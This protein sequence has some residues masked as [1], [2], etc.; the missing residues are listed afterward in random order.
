MPFR[1]FT[2]L[3][4]GTTTQ[5]NTITGTVPA[6]C[7]AGDVLLIAAQQ[8]SGTNTLTVTNSGPTT[9]TLVSGPQVTT[10]NNTVYVWVMA[11]AAGDLGATV[12]V[13]APG[14]GYFDGA[15]H[16]FS[17]VQVTGLVSAVASITAAA[18]TITTPAVTTTVANC[19]IATILALRSTATT[20]PTATPPSSQTRDG[21]ATTGA[22]GASPS[23]T[24]VGGHRTTPGA[25]GSYGNAAW[26]L[27]SASTGSAFT[28]AL[29]PTS[30][31]GSDTGFTAS[32]VDSG[33]TVHRCD[34]FYADASGALVQV[35]S[36][37]S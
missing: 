24:V 1:A 17:G 9:P 3:H 7:A 19:D 29:Q 25:A 30:V 27:S 13:T 23:F 10:N 6:A 14:G 28:V 34:V 33:G 18:T 22:S 11:L 20:S 16:A 15:L 12:T 4:S 26:T 36:K 21:A 37:T 31:A 2:A 8:S 5:V 32:Y 35:S